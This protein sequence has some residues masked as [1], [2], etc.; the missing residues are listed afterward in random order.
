MTRV[1]NVSTMEPVSIYS[2]AKAI[3][4]TDD[5]KRE[6]TPDKYEN[7]ALVKPEAMYAVVDKSSKKSA[8]AKNE[9]KMNGLNAITNDVIKNDDGDVHNV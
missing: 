9:N 1:P 6:N 3:N 4:E 2:V 8:K 5:I 7:V